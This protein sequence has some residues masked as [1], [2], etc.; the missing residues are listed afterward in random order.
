MNR[1]Y[2]KS[3]RWRKSLALAILTSVSLTANAQSNGDTFVHLFEWNWTD[4]GRECTEFLGPKGFKA[5]QVP[6]PQEH[7]AK[8]YGALDEDA[9]WVRYQ[10]MSYSIGNSRSGTEQQFR[11][12]VSECNQAGVD[13]Y[14]DAV[15]NH[16]AGDGG[17]GTVS[18]MGRYASQNNY[19]DVPY[20]AADFHNCGKP[21]IDG[22]DYQNNAANVRNCDLVRLDDLKTES[23]NVRSKIIG[24]LNGLTAM[25]VKGYRIDAAKH[26]AP[27][28]IQNIVSRLN[29]IAGTNTPVYVF[30]EVIDKS[31]GQEAITA[32]E[33]TSIADVT[34]FQWADNIGRKFQGLFEPS[35]GQ[36]GKLADLET[37]GSPAWGMLPSD[38][39][40][41]FVSNHDDQRGDGRF[42]I[43]D[44][45][46]E[47]GLNFIAEAYQMAQPYGYPKIM[48]SYY[49]NAN[50]D[51][52][53]SR[54]TV[55]TN[56]PTGGCEAPYGP[57]RG[58]SEGWVCEHRWTGL[59]NMVAFRKTAENQ[60]LTNW[61]SNGA[62]QIAF[63]RNGA[64]FI[65]INHESYPLVQQLQ[66]G[67][68][69]GQYCDIL[70][71]DFVNN[72]CTGDIITVSSGQVSV[73][74]PNR[75]SAMAIHT[76]AKIGGGSGSNRQVSFTCN[77]GST[78]LGTSVYVVG[79]SAQL[80]NWSPN[81]A[82]KLDPTAYPTWSATISLPAN[83]AMEWKCI[84]R[85]ESGGG[86]QWQNGSNNQLGSASTSTSGSF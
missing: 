27:A 55:P 33:Y 38:K 70:S 43:V 86:V 30:Q 14:V 61:W 37:I 7:R 77:N 76:G 62:N 34:E 53:V 82:I 9:W 18:S 20:S 49:F 72:S 8:D 39:A 75:N 22:S 63:G 68:A 79:D 46:D 56:S 41:I 83:Q 40:V 12:M 3:R 58:G 84:K 65:A 36:N 15:I 45:N 16:M 24:F 52:S 31:P 54:P 81:S 17:D 2:T 28:D 69:D 5:V 50:E 29:P 1:P 48:S 51:R 85:L 80:G 10:P 25:G 66:T 35:F 74:L 21:E 59:A 11:D 67:M 32:S 60:A 23:E 19:P 26:M 73:N 13:I 44:Y 4:I 42:A 47:F 6:P 64:G 78:N 57:N 71:G